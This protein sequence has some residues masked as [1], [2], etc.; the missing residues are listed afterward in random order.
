MLKVNF[1]IKYDPT[2]LHA[3]QNRCHIRNP[4]EILPQKDDQEKFS[5]LKNGVNRYSNR[6]QRGTALKA[7]ETAP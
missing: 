1:N 7:I 3:G 4:R 2:D 5:S 6:I